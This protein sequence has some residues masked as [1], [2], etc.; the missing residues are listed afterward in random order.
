MEASELR[1]GIAEI[2]GL[3]AKR[4][5]MSAFGRLAAVSSPDDDF[6]SQARVARLYST[7]P[8]AELGFKPI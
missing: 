6:V 3:I 4:D 5:W 8:A 7:L 2:K 1:G